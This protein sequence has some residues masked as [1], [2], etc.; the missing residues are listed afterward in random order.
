MGKTMLQKNLVR[1]KKEKIHANSLD[2]RT[3]YGIYAQYSFME[4]KEIN[5]FPDLW[6]IVCVW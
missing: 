3:W 5:T 4:V 6:Y 2:R 1:N